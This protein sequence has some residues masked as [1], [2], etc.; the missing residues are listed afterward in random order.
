MVEYSDFDGLLIKS[1]LLTRKFDET[2]CGEQSLL[3]T[4]CVIAAKYF[5][6]TVKI[7]QTTLLGA[8]TRA[9][10]EWNGEYR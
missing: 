2:I 9:N 5:V 1:G 6:D 3:V 10:D 7:N 8:T 4:I